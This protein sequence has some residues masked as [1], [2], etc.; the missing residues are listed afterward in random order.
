MAAQHEAIH[1][2]AVDDQRAHAGQHEALRRGA[3]LEV[4]LQRRGEPECRSLAWHAGHADA[5]AQQRDELPADGQAEARAAEAPGSR[6][7]LLR[8][9]LE[10]A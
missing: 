6:C 1:V 2:V 3:R 7:I 5:A 8:E 10:D 9:F 4:L